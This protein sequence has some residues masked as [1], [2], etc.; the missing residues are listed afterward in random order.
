MS[1]DSR[2]LDRG[3]SLALYVVGLGAAVSSY[4]HMVDLAARVRPELDAF[5]VHAWP[6]W[7][8]GMTIA[9]SLQL[10]RAARRGERGSVSARVA[11]VIGVALSLWAN[12]AAAETL[13]GRIITG[14]SSVA[15]ALTLEI[16]LRRRVLEPNTRPTEQPA[17]AP[18]RDAATPPNTERPAADTEAG[19]V[20]NTSSD[21]PPP[22]PVALLN[23]HR[24]NGHRARTPAAT[25]A[26]SSRRGS[27]AR[28]NTDEGA[29]RS[30]ILAAL[31]E[32]DGKVGVRQLARDLECSPS[33]VSTVLTEVRAELEA[34]EQAG[35][36]PA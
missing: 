4:V 17:P 31:K 8:D 5:T 2:G 36:V 23:G 11:L 14:S 27:R 20:A 33:Y 10:V 21:T 25:S 7:I 1:T 22:A 15:F 34:A 32:H 28:V 29:V 24:V 26:N 16:V 9:A 6:L 12:V 19:G 3:S 13:A 35:E 18:A 30:Q